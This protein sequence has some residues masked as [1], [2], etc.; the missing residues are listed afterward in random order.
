M[1]LPALDHKQPKIATAAVFTLKEIIRQF[2]IKVL[3]LKP[4][5]KT[6]PKMFGHSDKNV[7]A[8]ATNLALEAYKYLKQAMNPYLQELKPVQ[9]KELNEA[10]EK[11]PD[12]KAVPTRILRSQQ[13]AAAAAVAE[14]AQAEPEEE[15]VDVY[16]LVDAVDLLSKIN[17][18]FYTNLAS[19]KWKERKEAMEGLLEHAKAPK[20]QSG[21]YAELLGALAKRIA[22]VNIVCAVVAAN[23]V[24]AIALG[25]RKGFA[26]YKELVLPPLIDK[27]KEKKQNV[28]DALRACLDAVFKCVELPQILDEFNTGVNHK[29]PN[30]KAETVRWLTRCLKTIKTPPGKGEIKTFIDQL[31]K[32][33]EDSTPDVRESS[34]EAVG[35]L[36]KAAGERAVQAHLEGLDPIKLGK[37]KEYHDKAEVKVVFTVPKKPAPAAAKQPAKKG[38]PKPAEDVDEFNLEMEAPK[39]PPPKRLG[40]KP[41]A[42][43]PPADEEGEAPPAPKPAA[44]PKKKP[45]AAAAPPPAA[46]K[47]GAKPKD[48]EPVKFRFNSESA[49]ELIPQSFPATI[50]KEIADGNWKIRLAAVEAFYTHVEQE[51]DEVEPE[52]VVRQLAKKPGWKESNFQVTA[53]SFSIMELMARNSSK[54]TKAPCAL[55]IPALADKLGDMKL[56]KAAGDTLIAYAEKFSLQFVLGLSYDPLKKQKSPKVLADSLVWVKDVLS[57]F[58]IAG[59]AIRELI[60]FFKFCFASSNAQVRNNAVTAIGVLR[61]FAGPSTFCMVG[62]MTAFRYPFVFGRFEP[63]PA[64]HGGCRV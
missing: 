50:L 27:C 13:A 29:N 48:D 15:V 4:V 56:K 21:N 33:L 34:F 26:G 10:F 40:A 11:L 52:L 55:T 37:V 41:K 38:K 32:T 31:L 42:T 1:V 7:R 47:K 59:L 35:T 49:E 6:F 64:V 22:D 58:G 39:K 36:M 45:A 62:W 18:E 44:A 61:M 60:D 9:Q 53:K 54:F 12:E 43:D 5:L 46:G 2:G 28:V 3:T 24:E 14:S 25:L 17:E 23:L 63:Q 20:L 30:V 57:D 16:D 8:E 51:M 19:S